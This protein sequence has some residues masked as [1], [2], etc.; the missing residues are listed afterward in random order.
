MRDERYYR[1]E[2]RS[3]DA[4]RE[5]GGGWVWNESYLIADDVYFAESA[6]T[7][8]RILRQLRRMGV[9]SEHSKGRVRVYDGDFVIEVQDKATGQPLVA[10][11]LEEV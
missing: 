8:R 2:I 10:L 9:L 7:P 6:L 5:L 4:I 11:L 1:A 3:I